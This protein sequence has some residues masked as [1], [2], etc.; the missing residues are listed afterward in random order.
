MDSGSVWS[1]RYLLV[2]VASV[3]RV[4]RDPAHRRIA[5]MGPL[6]DGCWRQMPATMRERR[7]LGEEGHVA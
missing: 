6:P 2:P 1:V 5:N 4:R 3:R 7:R